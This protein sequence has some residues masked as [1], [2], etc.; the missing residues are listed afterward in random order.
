MQPC[1]LEKVAFALEEGSQP[2]QLPHLIMDRAE[3][4]QFLGGR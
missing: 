2:N 1:T 3:I 4:N